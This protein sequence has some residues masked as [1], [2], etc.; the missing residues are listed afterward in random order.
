MRLLLASKSEARRKMLEA[1]GVPFETVEAE[2]DEAA[3]KGGLEAAGF[4]PRGIAEELA[5]LKALSVQAASDALVL[6]SDQTLEL[7]DG[8]MMSKPGSREEAYEQ[9]A[10]L[11]GRTH[12]LH[13][14]A[15]VAQA[16]EAVWWHCETVEM[17]M[18][19]FGEDFLRDY[20]DREYEQVR[21]SVGGYRIEGMGAQ[22]FERIE[23]SHFAILG[24]PLLPLLGYLRER[25]LLKS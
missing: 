8:S 7:D 15:V 24:M 16:G 3:A 25:G 10:I 23:G 14:S 13:S 20:L 2:L 5:Q 9:L 17:T 12:L 19:H 18:R 6:G 11:S 22:L 4:D 1:A 21:W